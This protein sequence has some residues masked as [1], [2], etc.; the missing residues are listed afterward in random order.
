M[1]AGVIEYSWYVRKP[2]RLSA[3]VFATDAAR[4][5]D[6]Y[7]GSCSPIWYR[8]DRGK[9]HFVFEQTLLAPRS[10]GLTGVAAF[11]LPPMSDVVACCF[12]VAVVLRDL[13]RPADPW[14]VGESG[15]YALGL[16]T[17]DVLLLDTLAGQHWTEMNIGIDWRTLI[18][19]Q[20]HCV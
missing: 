7:F 3:R 1:A 16:S 13:L 15:G 6:L 9:R 19:V 8:Q 17:I 5:W 12:H 14:D 4:R 18:W 11:G 10:W 2:S 20:R